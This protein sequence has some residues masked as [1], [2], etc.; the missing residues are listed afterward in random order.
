MEVLANLVQK[1]DVN[2]IDVIDGLRN[3]E[4]SWRDWVFEKEGKYYHGFEESAGSHS[5]S[6][7]EEITKAKYDYIEALEFVKAY[8]KKYNKKE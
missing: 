1:V 8:I 3:K 4:I 5:F 6:S 2:P 7:K